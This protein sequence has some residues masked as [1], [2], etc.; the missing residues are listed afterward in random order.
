MVV[1]VTTKENNF[2]RVNLK[3]LIY[4]PVVWKEPYREPIQLP[5][6]F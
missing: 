2:Y 3:K 1:F 6:G 5:D 4:E